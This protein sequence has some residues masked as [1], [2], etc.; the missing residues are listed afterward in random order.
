MSALLSDRCR[1]LI[2][3]ARFYD[4]LADA[5]LAGAKAELEKQGISY[6]VITVPGALEIPGAIALVAE[7]GLYDGFVALGCVIRG[8]TSHYDIVSGESARGI[9]DLT[10]LKRLAIG[11]G[12]ITCENEQQAWARAQTGRMDK[13]GQAAKAAIALTR[14][15]QDF[16]RDKSN[17]RGT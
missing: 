2:V 14:L 15:N 13:G 11:N 5:L 12:I 8:E 17:E 4:G 1:F 16:H 7:T 3:E 6:D 10:I 9:M